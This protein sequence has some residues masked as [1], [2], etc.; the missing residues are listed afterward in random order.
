MVNDSWSG[1]WEYTRFDILVRLF[2]ILNQLYHEIISPS[3]SMAFQTFRFMRWL[4]RWWKVVQDPECGGKEGRS[5]VRFLMMMRVIIGNS[6]GAY[7][8]K[9]PQYVYYFSLLV[10]LALILI[11]CMVVELHEFSR[12]HH[13][14]ID[15][16]LRFEHIYSSILFN[17][18]LPESVGAPQ[19]NQVT[20][21]VPDCL[22]VACKCYI[23]N[24]HLRAG[25]T[26]TSFK[27]ES[28]QPVHRQVA[29]CRPL[30][31]RDSGFISSDAAVLH[32][33]CDPHEALLYL[34]CRPKYLLSC[35]RPLDQWFF[36]QWRPIPF[37]RSVFLITSCKVLDISANLT[38][39]YS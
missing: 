33:G 11:W 31:W 16:L 27:Y 17:A 14:V 5:N 26:S 29:V 39:V 23:F 22:L 6:N 37:L 35:K 30:T 36:E 20:L 15:Y 10:C 25:G 9:I 18:S 28:R 21:V 2:V 13:R 24:L 4:Y 38:S 1:S 19:L 3:N 7:E 12:R 8:A 34:R 32:C